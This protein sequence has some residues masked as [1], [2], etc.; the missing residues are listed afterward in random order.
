VRILFAVAVSLLLTA[1][2]FAQAKSAQTKPADA[3]RLGLTCAQVLQM[4][5]AD[6]VLKFSKE[7]DATTQGTLRAI[8]AYG[9]C[10]DARTD[11]LAA[12]LAKTR[13]GPRPADVKSFR[14]FDQALKDFSSKA[15]ASTDPPADAVKSAYA[16]LYEKAFRYEF[17]QDFETGVGKAPT[18]ATDGSKQ[19]AATS[20]PATSRADKNDP[21]TRVKNHFGELLGSLSDDKRHEVHA[22]FGRIFEGNPYAEAK[23]LE[24]YRY[25]VFLLEP[26]SVAPFSPPPF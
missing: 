4:T 3:D 9:H 23:K 6:W 14:E 19:R 18:P 8:D 16:A 5:S 25:A 10:Y 12:A 21:F 13:K 7:K 2:S 26:P 1:A 24:V 22:A 17:F 20:P 15:L 11:R